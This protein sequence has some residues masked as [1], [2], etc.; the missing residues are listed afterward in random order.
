[1]NWKVVAS[2]KFKHKEDVSPSVYIDM[3]SEIA[4][5]NIKTLNQ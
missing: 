5:E 1:M 3:V 2:H 4:I